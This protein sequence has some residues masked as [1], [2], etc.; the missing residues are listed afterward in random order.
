MKSAA[1]ALI[2]MLLVGASVACA[3]I[4]IGAPKPAL[5][6]L[7]SARV[8][9]PER[10][11]YADLSKLVTLHPSYDFVRQSA[12]VSASVGRMPP[13]PGRGT[14]ALRIPPVRIDL[15]DP[16]VSREELE[17][18]TVWAAVQS[19]TPW[20]NGL[21]QSLKARL[22]GNWKTLKQVANSEIRLATREIEDQAA[23]ERRGVIVKYLFPRLNLYAKYAAAERANKIPGFES[24]SLK[25]SYQVA[26]AEYDSVMA[27]YNAE[28]AEIDA[29]VN[30]QTAGVRKEALERAETSLAVVDRQGTRK[31]A[32]R[33]AE[34]RD[35]IVNDTEL[36]STAG[37]KTGIDMKTFRQMDYGEAI[38]LPELPGTGKDV[39]AVA[40]PNASGAILQDVAKAVRRIAQEKRLAVVFTPGTAPD[41]T[42]MFVA[43]MRSRL[44]WGQGPA[45][46]GVGGNTKWK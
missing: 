8:Q 15:K 45:L 4:Y 40:L 26:K 18:D 6:Q 44:W 2:A 3:L 24:P 28:L 43:E 25:Q 23:V 31:I 32:Q 21:K 20:E 11:V 37:R 30:Q 7:P 13:A 10:T 14:V 41:E 36:A 46:A 17:S 1:Y 35:E 42:Q 33:V 34:V 19:L 29:R 9:T 39:S 27:Q 16:V 12:A 38:L 5:P 22:A